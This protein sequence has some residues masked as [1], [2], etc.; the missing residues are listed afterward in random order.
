MQNLSKRPLSVRSGSL[1][2]L[3]SGGVGRDYEDSLDGG[4]GQQF[5]DKEYPIR[6][7][8]KQRLNQ[9]KNVFSAIRKNLEDQTDSKI[10]DTL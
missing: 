1:Q 9:V 6:N 2:K 5:D 7:S 4:D 8:L 3:H 10:E